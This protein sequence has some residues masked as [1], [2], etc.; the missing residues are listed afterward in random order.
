M[1]DA[2]L[3]TSASITEA[4]V[5]VSGY[6]LLMRRL[7]GLLAAIFTLLVLPAAALG[8]SSA[9]RL[10]LAGTLS[11]A[12]RPAGH[13][14]GA[15]VVDLSTG[16]TLFS[17]AASIP[18]L[19]ASVEKIYTTSTALQRFGT[20]T[21]LLTSVWGS[22]YLDASGG[23]HGTLYLKGGGDPTFGSA[24][25][26]SYAYGTGAS[27]QRLVA[28]LVQS[29]GITSVSGSIV[30]DES[31]LDSLRGTAATGYRVS[32]DIEGLL[33]GLAYD[34]GLTSAAGT[35]FQS[36]PAL[37][38]AQQFAA[39]LRQ[40]HVAVPAQTKIYTG[41][42]PTGAQR[43]AAVHS[44]R[45]ATLIKLT[46]M[47]SDNFLAEMLLKDL[48]ARF[49][50]RGSSAAGAAVVRSQ[51][52]RSFRIHPRLVDGSGLSRADRTSPREV[53]AALTSL[54]NN[55]SF[56]NS[57]SVAGVSGTM[58]TGLHGTAAQRR[59]QGKT[60]TLHDVANLVGYCTA[61]NGHRLVFAFLMNSVDPTSGHAIEDHM[62]IDLAA[63]DG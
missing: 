10:A 26:D 15:E 34:R 52:A 48:G 54:A 2:I 61:R 1:L 51:L 49:G 18:R 38:A 14:D 31:F 23:W 35:A 4:L 55:Q 42:V 8:Q 58:K 21:N 28:N 7:V 6:I 40:A 37:F 41:I 53:I 56:V 11:R 62:A 32:T 16:E 47:P 60:G 19:P 45:M 36:R 29:C 44:P 46:N 13:S 63:Y 27:M 33:S 12:L 39:A 25:Y 22:G 9:A 24:S 59:C 5:A 43:M 3:G 30:G 17:T 50:A 20:N 57:L